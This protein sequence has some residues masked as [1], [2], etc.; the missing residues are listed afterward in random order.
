MPLVKPGCWC[1]IAMVVL[2]V[3]WL[4]GSGELLQTAH[5]A[6]GQPQTYLKAQNYQE[7]YMSNLLSRKYSPI[8]VLVGYCH[9][10]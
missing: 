6:V 4:M 2:P 3:T 7:T 8:L 9:S 10:I 1:T 5:L